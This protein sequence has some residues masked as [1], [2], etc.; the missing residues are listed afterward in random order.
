MGPLLF[1]IY[2]YINDLPQVSA[3]LDMLMYA[4]DTTIYWYINQN[5]K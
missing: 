2:V 3:F 4:D 5:V 1:L